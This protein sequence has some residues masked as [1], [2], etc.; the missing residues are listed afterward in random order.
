M[1]TQTETI[2]RAIGSFRYHMQQLWAPPLSETIRRTA[3]CYTH[4]TPQRRGPITGPFPL[5][6]QSVLIE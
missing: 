2:G 5:I 6:P 1:R 3:D 4:L